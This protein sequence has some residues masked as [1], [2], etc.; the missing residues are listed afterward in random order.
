[1]S[2]RKTDICRGTDRQKDRE[3]VRQKNID[4]VATLPEISSDAV[5]DI[6]IDLTLEL[7]DRKVTTLS[8]FNLM[9]IKNMYIY[10]YILS[11][12]LVMVGTG[13]EI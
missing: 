8:S 10:E 12:G 7:G 11:R 2:N 9:Y 3:V 5:V 13:M 6:A 4:N 1:M